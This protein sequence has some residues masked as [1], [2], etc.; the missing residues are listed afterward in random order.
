MPI[1]RVC[2]LCGCECDGDNY[3]DIPAIW[4]VDGFETI[5][6]GDGSENDKSC[7][8]KFDKRFRP[9][10]Q[11][12]MQD[13]QRVAQEEVGKAAKAELDKMKEE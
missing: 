3:F 5:C 4:K 13:A 10:S 12:I 6:A 1:K 11:K 7:A 8:T 2:D 9:I